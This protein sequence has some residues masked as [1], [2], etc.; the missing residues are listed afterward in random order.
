MASKH[1]HKHEVHPARLRKEFRLESNK[2]GFICAG[3]SI[4]GGYKRNVQY[5]L[6]CLLQTYC[7]LSTKEKLSV[8]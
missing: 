3:A 4:V 1:G 6:S 8:S 5:N 7:N 2:F